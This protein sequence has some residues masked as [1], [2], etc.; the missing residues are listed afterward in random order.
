MVT[1]GD[2]VGVEMVRP[3]AD[4]A[5]NTLTADVVA[6]GGAA[7]GF[8]GA[9]EMVSFIG[10]EAGQHGKTWENMGKRGKTLWFDMFDDVFDAFLN[11]I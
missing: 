8:P 4:D 7:A 6:A 9:W 5:M 3:E 10:M 2:D 11:G 1:A